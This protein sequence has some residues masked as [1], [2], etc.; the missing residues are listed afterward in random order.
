MTSPSTAAGLTA[1]MFV[2][3]V[4]IP[5]MAALNAKLG[6]GLGSPFAASAILFV[7]GAVVAV[8]A[9][10]VTGVPARP[11]QWPAPQYWLGGTLVAFYVLAVTFSAPRIGIG[12]AIFM[13]LLGQIAAAAAIDQF[14]LFGAVKS[15]LTPM[16]MVGIA[17]M[18]VGVFLAKKPA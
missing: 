17:V 7:V 4:G 3:G 15:P 6:Q 8:I 5:V 10:L 1:L 13:V 14:G 2:A 12:T 18:C 9:L 16:R 11:A